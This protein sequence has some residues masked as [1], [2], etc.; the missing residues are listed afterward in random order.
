LR[1]RTT[2]ISGGLVCRSTMPP[3]AKTG[4]RAIF[5]S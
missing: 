5:H 4:A 3:A 1:S 2:A